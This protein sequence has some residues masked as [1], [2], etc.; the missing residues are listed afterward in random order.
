M[1]TSP[2]HS[3]R[4]N[5]MEL[6]QE[7]PV[8]AASG[9]ACPRRLHHWGKAG[10]PLACRAGG[11]LQL[12]RRIQVWSCH[13]PLAARRVLRRGWRALSPQQEAVGHW[14]AHPYP[15]P[16][17]HKLQS[18]RAT[19]VWGMI[20]GSKM[21]SCHCEIQWDAT[22]MFSAGHNGN[23]LLP[24]T[25]LPIARTQWYTVPSCLTHRVVRKQST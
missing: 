24:C 22:C 21:R 11:D 3:P 18:G 7:L 9:R 5:K 19:F 4:H 8:A 10:L 16:H 17:V 1:S 12:P 25:H 15:T 13:A 20:G 14:R 2:I 23:V 6:E